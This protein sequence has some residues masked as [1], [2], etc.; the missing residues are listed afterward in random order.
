MSLRLARILALTGLVVALLV[1]ALWLFGGLA[2]VE[3]WAA[4]QQ[5]TA[6][7]LMAGALRALRA[8]QPGAS[9]SLAWVCFGYGVFHAIG[10]GHGKLIIGSYGFGSSVPMV[11]LAALSIAA[12]LAQA[13]TAVALVWGGIAVLDLGREALTDLSEQEMLQ[14][15]TVLVAGVGLWLAL[16]GLRMLRAE[17][18]H[19][20]HH[21]GCGCGHAHGPTPVQVAQ[22]RSLRDGLLVVAGIAARPC[23]GALFLLI[24]T[25]RMGIFGMGIL[26]AFA[27]GLGTASVTLAVA[28]MAVWARRGSLAL[29]PETPAARWVPGVMQLGSGTLIALVSLMVLV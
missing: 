21:D 20:H 6:H 2:G 29:L 17:A 25:W 26:G 27:M 4:T 7:N 11:R 13:A 18:Q 8:G 12:S 16:R 9:M 14:V 3:R 19:H 24:L 28:G 1:A 22:T 23:T 10:P 5:R 15:S